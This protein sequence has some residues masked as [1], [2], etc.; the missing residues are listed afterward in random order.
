MGLKQRILIHPDIFYTNHSGAIAA[1]EAARL[2]T[3]LGFEVAIFTHD[4]QNLDLA[5]YKYYRRIP[6][7]GTA[8]YL[9]AKYRNSII[10][11]IDDFKPDFVFFIG[12]IINTPVVYFDVC[13]TKGI[14]TVFLLLVQDFFCARLHAGRGNSSCKLCLEKSNFYAFKYFCTEKQTKPILSLVN[15]QLIQSMFLKRLKKIDFVLGSSDE[16][17][18]FYYQIGINR[19]KTIKIPLFFDQNRVKKTDIQTLPYFVIIGQYRHEKGMHLISSILEYLEPKIIIK[20]IFYNQV[21]ADSFIKR[22]P[23]NEKH[24]KNGSL[25]ILPGVTIENGALDLIASSKG[26]INPTIWATTTEFVLLEILGMGKPIITFGVGIHKEIIKNRIN[27]IVVEP[28]DFKNMAN[29]INFLFNN[30]ELEK[31]ISIEALKLYHELTDSIIFEN[32]L[33]QI[34]K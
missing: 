5:N 31:A 20:V 23:E 11:T 2:L 32:K 22:Y 7:N 9:R 6:Y 33:L 14:K 4:Q 30:P 10:Q 26:V 16:Q 19:N 13:F 17:L 18:S 3:L 15:Y 28:G 25:E 34:F 12:G 21:E 1:R 24:I 27:G 29:E 8:N